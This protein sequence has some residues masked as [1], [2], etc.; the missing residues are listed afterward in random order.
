M[1]RCVLSTSFSQER[2]S[3]SVHVITGNEILVVPD[4]FTS[5]ELV[6]AVRGVTG[7]EVENRETD[8]KRF[9]NAKSTNEEFWNECVFHLQY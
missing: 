6:S 9:D 1:D 4:V 5:R 3:L 2:L 8:R 7:K